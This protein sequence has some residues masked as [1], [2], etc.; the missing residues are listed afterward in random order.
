MDPYVL[1]SP[2]SF[3]SLEYSGMFYV[4][5]TSAHGYVGMALNFHSDKQ[6]LLA[7]WKKDTEDV[8]TGGR[9]ERALAGM[10]VKL[11]NY[12]TGPS[13]GKFYAA[14]RNTGNTDGQ[15]SL[16]SPPLTS[17][18]SPRLHP[19]TKRS[20]SMCCESDIL[21]TQ[22]KTLWRDLRYQGWE[23]QHPY[24]WRIIYSDQTSCMR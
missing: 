21:L 2:T 16:S 10:Q 3:S 23:H 24:R 5:K 19:S 22:V 11:F 18:P 12:T 13:Y 17:I 7:A 9:N 20:G 14:L 4:G 1:L 8:W 15:V 6:F